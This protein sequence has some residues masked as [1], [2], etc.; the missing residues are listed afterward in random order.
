[1][2]R[3]L[4][5]RLDRLRGRI[6]FGRFITL[7]IANEHVEDSALIDATLSAARIERSDTDLVVLLKRYGTLG[8]EP[9]CSLVSVL[10]LPSNAR[11]RCD[12]T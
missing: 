5:R 6:A 3:A 4:Q 10:P 8:T 2:T 1:M 11:K 12:A 9:P 7:S